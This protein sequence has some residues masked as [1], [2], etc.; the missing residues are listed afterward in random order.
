M[1]SA[2][3][4]D[5]RREQSCRIYNLAPSVQVRPEDT[6]LLFYCSKGPR[7]YFLNS[8]NLLSTNYFGSGITLNQWFEK[9]LLENNR[10]INQINSEQMVCEL[11]EKLGNALEDLVKKGVLIC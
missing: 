1:E 3:F 6:G 10:Q 11:L 9:K 8:G 5:K 4:T 2:A 7:L